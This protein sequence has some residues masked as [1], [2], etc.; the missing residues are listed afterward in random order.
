M[1][2]A[3]KEERVFSIELRS[4]GDLRNAS[5]END[6]KVS[7]EGSLGTLKQARFVDGIVLE[8]IGSKGELRVDLGAGDLLK[9]SKQDER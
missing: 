6:H 1:S 2:Q 9:N 3:K 8:V 7:I 5:F 4:R